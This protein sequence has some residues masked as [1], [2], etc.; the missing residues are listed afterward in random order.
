LNHTNLGYPNE[1]VFNGAQYSSSGGVIQ[2][3]ATPSRQIQFALK[4]QF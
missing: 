1:V 3:T 4:L 2:A